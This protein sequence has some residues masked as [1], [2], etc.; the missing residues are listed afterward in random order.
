MVD[1]VRVLEGAGI[2]SVVDSRVAPAPGTFTPVGVV[3]HH[4]AA[5]TDESSNRKV[6]RRGRA[7]LAGPLCNLYVRRDG[8][9]EVITDGR[10]ND[11]GKGSSTVLDEVSA[12]RAVHRD[13]KDRG[14]GSDVSG[15]R[16]FFDIEID[17]RGTG[18]EDY[19]SA[20]VEAA[21]RSAA[22]L[23]EHLGR[24]A[25]SLIFHRTWTSRKIDPSLRDPDLIDLTRRFLEEREAADREITAHSP[26]NRH[27]H[28]TVEHRWGDEPWARYLDR[29]GSSVPES[30]VWPAHREDIAW[31]H[32]LLMDRIEHLE[33]RVR[34]LEQR[35][36]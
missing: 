35:Q 31:V 19:P 8:T 28:S 20:Q 13:A 22:A 17:N 32:G 29:G 25:G 24:D 18:T 33:Q 26:A 36:D 9:V 34:T 11:T 27:A 3:L 2:R 5:G 1:L 10:A 6:L 23:L 16:W 15:N 30:R 12:G 7:G 21:A 14:L 4:T